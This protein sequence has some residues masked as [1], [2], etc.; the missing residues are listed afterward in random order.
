[1]KL[2]K[3]KCKKTNKKYKGNGT[4]KW[5]KKTFDMKLKNI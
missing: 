3:I 2:N 4:V 5:I 1:M